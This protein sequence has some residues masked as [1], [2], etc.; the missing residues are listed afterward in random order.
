MCKKILDLKKNMEKTENE[1]IFFEKT[2][3]RGHDY[4]TVRIFYKDSKDEWKPTQK[5]VTLS[6]ERFD[7]FKDKI[8]EL[9]KVINKV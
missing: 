8:L 9:E 7:E 1:K 2:K 3:Y 4:F 5:G 6:I